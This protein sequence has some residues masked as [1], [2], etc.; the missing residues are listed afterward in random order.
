MLPSA[1]NLLIKP[2]FPSLAHPLGLLTYLVCF[3]RDFILLNSP[4]LYPILLVST[5]FKIHFPDSCPMCLSLSI[6]QH[7]FFP[8]SSYR[9]S[10]CALWV[11]ICCSSPSFPCLV[12]IFLASHS[13]LVHLSLCLLGFMLSLSC[14]ELL[15]S[16]VP[17]F[18][19]FFPFT[20]GNGVAPAPPWQT[21]LLGQWKGALVI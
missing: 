9:S 13:L 11:S 2:H 12:L 15:F 20:K 1:F 8:F 3:P 5:I 21:P 4:F 14:F 17:Y 18:T 19:S 16:P 7:L 10:F 6:A